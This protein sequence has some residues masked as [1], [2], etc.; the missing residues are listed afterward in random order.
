MSVAS[1]KAQ[2]QQHFQE[3]TS[4]VWG[5]RSAFVKHPNGYF[6]LD[7]D[8]SSDQVAPAAKSVH[9]ACHASHDGIAARWR[10][11]VGRSFR[12]P[13]RMLSVTHLLWCDGDFRQVQLM[14]NLDLFKSTLK[15]MEIDVSKMPLGKLSRKY[16]CSFM[17]GYPARRRHLDGAYEVLTKLQGYLDDPALDDATRVCTTTALMSHT[18]HHCTDVTHSS[19][20]CTDVTHSSSPCSIARFSRRPRSS[21]RVRCI[22]SGACRLSAASDPA[23]LWTSPAAA[24]RH[25]GLCLSISFCCNTHTGA[26]CREDPAD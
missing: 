17:H 2:F 23:R 13:S 20:P 11:A 24:H 9:G 21:T 25:Q 3:K 14:F 22:A 26:A 5:D 4:N 15:E 16:V 8:Y 12:A 10:P 18:H 6:P 19:S 1:A 7:L